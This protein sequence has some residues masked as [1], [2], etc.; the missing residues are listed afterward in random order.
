MRKYLWIILSIFIILGILAACGGADAPADEAGVAEMAPAEARSNKFVRTRATVLFADSMPNIC[1]ILSPVSIF[2][3]PT[4][5]GPT[6]P[7]SL[8]PARIWS[9]RPIRLEKKVCVER[10][11][12][13]S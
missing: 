8:A 10:R 6:C 3:R 11:F 9:E 13:C 7:V 2:K 12:P 5:N 1:P 4:D